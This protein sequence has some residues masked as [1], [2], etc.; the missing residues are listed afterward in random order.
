MS[1]NNNTTQPLPTMASTKEEVV[2]IL[3][4]MTIH[5][6]SNL[7][8]FSANPILLRPPYT[9]PFG[10]QAA[11]PI[12]LH[13]TGSIEV[14][15][16]APLDTRFVNGW[17]KLADELKVQILKHNLG[18]RPIHHYDARVKVNSKLLPHLQMSPDIA[19]LAEETF[20]K[21]NTFVVTPYGSHWDRRFAYPPRRVNTYIRRLS[22]V[23]DMDSDWALL[24]KLARGDYG[25]EN[26]RHVTL[27]YEFGTADTLLGLEN[28]DDER[29]YLDEHWLSEPIVFHPEGEITLRGS[30]GEPEKD[31]EL[32]E[33][34]RGRIKFGFVESGKE[35]S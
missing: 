2:E 20:Y 9:E 24:R 5:P 28:G 31:D 10:I 19:R 29:R 16:T 23:T 4:P 14:E 8:I 15:S 12:R 11:T 17:N 34:L 25:F 35:G 1:N 13:N 30:W 26:L 18:C 27:T 32:L 3:T 7:R 21:H 33:L 22:I 6:G